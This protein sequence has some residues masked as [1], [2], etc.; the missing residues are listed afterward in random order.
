MFSFKLKEQFKAPKKVYCIDSG[1]AANI[2]F[3][4]SKDQGKIME[5]VVFIELLRRKLY[6]N[7]DWE[8]YYWKDHR[9]REIDFVVKASESVK[10]LVQ[11]TYAST[12]DEIEPRELEAFEVAAAELRC[13]NLLVITWDYEGV[14]AIGNKTVKLV[15]LWKWLLKTHPT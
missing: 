13:E 10:Q 4:L 15:P 7:L 5:N 1:L 6:Q 8:L 3:K 9:G 11:V 2:A 14:T 12:E